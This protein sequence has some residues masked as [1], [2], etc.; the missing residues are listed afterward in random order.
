MARWLVSLI[1]DEM[2]LE[3]FPR[4]FPDGDPYAFR[5]RDVTYLAGPDVGQFATD[6][7]ALNHA[8]KMVE[9]LSTVISL[10]QTDFQRPA[11]G[12]F[13]RED[14]Q[15]RRRRI[16]VATFRGRSKVIGRSPSAPGPTE[17]QRLLTGGR[18]SLGLRT[19]L[20]LWGVPEPEWWRLVRIIEEIGAVPSKNTPKTEPYYKK[21]RHFKNCADSGETAGVLARHPGQAGRPIADPMS[22][23]EARMFVRELLLQKLR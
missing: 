16:G 23:E 10:L 5:K 17:A 20:V 4:C 1:G 12:S 21:W 6:D 15:G 18:G 19:A 13:F 11:V 2:D 14:D 3:E 7:Q 9:E 8:V 22:V